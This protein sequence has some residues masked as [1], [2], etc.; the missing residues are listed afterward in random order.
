M[1]HI[2]LLEE[3]SYEIEIEALKQGLDTGDSLLGSLRDYPE[4]IQFEESLFDNENGPMRFRLY[5]RSYVGKGRFDILFNEETVAIPFEVRSKK[6]GYFSEYPRM[7]EDIAE[8]S[9]TLL[10]NRGSPLFREYALKS[11]HRVGIYEDFLLLDHIFTKR[12]LE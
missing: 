12:S 8:H 2:L 11:G 7:I 3:T 4:S 5:F 9:V 1:E 6:I 10:L